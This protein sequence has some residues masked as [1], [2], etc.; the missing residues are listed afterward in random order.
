[1]IQIIEF[2]IDLMKNS[3]IKLTLCPGLAVQAEDLGLKG[4]GFDSREGQSFA[5]TICKGDVVG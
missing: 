3:T 5:F 2:K 1:M 4:S